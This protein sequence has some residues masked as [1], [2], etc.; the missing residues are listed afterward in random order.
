MGFAYRSQRGGCVMPMWGPPLAPRQKCIGIDLGTNISRVSYWEDGDVI[1]VPN[2]NGRL[3][4]PSCVAFC[5]ERGV[6]VGE[7]ADDQAERNAENTIYAPQRFLGFKM[8]NPWVRCY[9]RQWPIKVCQGEDGRLVICVG[10]AEK[11]T[12]KQDSERWLTPEE[13]TT[14]LLVYLR[15]LAE[16]HLGTRVVD[17]VIT[18]P[19]RFGRCQ[20]EALLVAC[21]EARLHVVEFLKAPTASAIAY[22]LT[23]PLEKDRIVLVC[24]VGG[25]YFDF[26]LCRM[27]DG[28]VD[29]L[30]VGTDMVDLDDC[31]VRFCIKEFEDSTGKRLVADANAL[32]KLRRACET[33]K[34]RLSQYNQAIVEVLDINEGVDY[35]RTISRARLEELCRPIIS[36]LVEPLS[37]CLDEVSLDKAD[38]AEVVLVGGSARVPLIR[39]ALKDFFHGRAPREVFR[40]E[41]AAVLGAA[42]RGESIVGAEAV[43]EPSSPSGA[44]MR[45]PTALKKLT[46]KQVTTWPTLSPQSHGSAPDHDAWTGEEESHGLPRCLRGIRRPSASQPRSPLKTKAA[47]FST[48]VGD[49][50]SVL[51]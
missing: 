1:V 22:G 12:G 42:A 11:D 24:N 15:R 8:T 31:L 28:T 36:L 18:V 38:V 4:S 5:P 46:V 25:S 3:G 40:P 37:Y 6:L 17:A 45:I 34:R 32:L 50:S 2:E 7:A 33:A 39:R 13:L 51:I 30:A 48:H 14:M 9:L 21:T 16:N 27:G 41:H 26:S 20:Q 35:M 49:G 10:G 47:P 29:E 43:S 44:A 19:S 23:N